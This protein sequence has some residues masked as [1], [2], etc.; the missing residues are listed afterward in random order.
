MFP[1]PNKLFYIHTKAKGLNAP[2]LFTIKIKIDKLW[3]K[4]QH[5]FRR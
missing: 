5:F 3:K 4:W 1:D 2:K